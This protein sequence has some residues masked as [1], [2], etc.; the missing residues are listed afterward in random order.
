VEHSLH[1]GLSKMQKFAAIEGLRAW[2]ALVVVLDHCAAGSDL[3]H[4]GLLR[5]VA[6][7][8]PVCVSVFI[9][10]SGFVI[11]H[12]IM[13]RQEPYGPYIVRRFMRIYP[14]FVVTCALGAAV[15]P[16][17]VAGMKNA[18]WDA[19]NYFADILASQNAHLGWHLIAHGLMLHGAIPDNILPFAS[20][21]F[22]GPAW[23]LS[24]EWQFYL[25]APAVILLAHKRVGAEALLIAS[26]VG[27]FLFFRGSLGDFPSVSFLPGAAPMFALG[28]ASRLYV[29]PALHGKI[30]HPTIIALCV[31]AF[32]PLASQAIMAALIWI[33]FSA[34][35][36]ADKN[37]SH[38]VFHLAFCSDTARYWGTRS[39][40]IYLCHAPVLFVISY[41][42]ARPTL[43]Q[44]PFF[45]LLV[46][47]GII[48]TALLSTLTYAVVE[49]P[50]MAI[51]TILA[52][53]VKPA[54]STDV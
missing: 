11:T 48:G 53:R 16:L 37:A 44:W 40:S 54:Y 8:G 21:A 22:L 18:G 4:H 9:I 19:G 3:H 52:E 28:I 13:E 2:L 39:Y 47:L 43:T 31:L 7:A 23:S 33:G 42:L 24:L 27:A 15:L 38:R 35:M 32:S 36:C 30:R 49:M 45:F 20:Y 29:W 12:L 10:I 25:I 41:F 26:A 50:G 46:P 1:L 14:L 6:E 17:Y 5:I 34:F 51:G